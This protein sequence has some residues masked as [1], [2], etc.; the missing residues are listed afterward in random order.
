MYVYVHIHIYDYSIKNGSMVRLNIFLNAG[1]KTAA[2]WKVKSGL[3]Y[4]LY[5]NFFLVE[6]NQC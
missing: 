4:S 6:F 5:A 3:K 2:M 1:E